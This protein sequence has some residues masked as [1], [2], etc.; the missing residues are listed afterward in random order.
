MTHDEARKTGKHGG[1]EMVW[2][3][4]PKDDP[5]FVFF[6]PCNTPCALAFRNKNSY[7]DLTDLDSV[8]FEFDTRG[9][10]PK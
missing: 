7:V 6:G 1:L 2:R 10:I 3:E 9:T 5:T 8:S 4:T